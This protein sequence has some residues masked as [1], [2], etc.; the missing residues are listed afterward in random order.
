[1]IVGK[2]NDLI[3]YKG[4]NKNL[5]TAI[6][7]IVNTDLNTLVDG[8]NEVDG[9]NVF[10]NK[11]IYTGNEEGDGFFE[12]HKDYL[13]IHMVLSGCEKLGYADIS[14]LTAVTEYDKNTDFT[15]FEGN[16][17][18]YIKLEPLDFALTFPEDIHMPK[19]KINDEKIEKLVCK[20]L[21]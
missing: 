9:D 14:E 4:L 12:G 15:K 3:R 21:L 10:I 11:F 19:I 17:K 8:R 6:D 5:D 13:D 7:F 1:M 2:I 16:I 18:N 20:V